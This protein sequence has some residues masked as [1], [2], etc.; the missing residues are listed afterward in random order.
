[1][2]R[3]QTAVEFMILVGV[4]LFFFIGFLLFVG[5]SSSHQLYERQ[6]LE[7]AEIARTVQEEVAFASSTVDGYQRTFLLPPQIVNLDYNLTLVDTRLYVRTFNGRHALAVPI[8]NV[9][10]TFMPGTNILRR[11]NGTVYANS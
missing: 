6:R 5:F 10:G 1:M 8:K 3:G 7:L 11:T 2:S 4:V 9:T